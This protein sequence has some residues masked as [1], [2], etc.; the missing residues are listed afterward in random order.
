MAKWSGTTNRENMMIDFQVWMC[1]YCSTQI[2]NNTHCE[3]CNE[4][5]GAMTLEE[6][7]T[8]NAIAPRVFVG[9]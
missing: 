1:G 3:N 8:F 4:Y 7:T 5:D 2:T 9:I 6:W